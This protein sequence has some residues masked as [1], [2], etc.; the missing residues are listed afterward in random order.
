MVVT[1][2]DHLQSDKLFKGTALP[3]KITQ[4]DETRYLLAIERS[5]TPAFVS[6]LAN[7][8]V[9]Y[10]TEVVTGTIG[11]DLAVGTVPEINQDYAEAL[12]RLAGMAPYAAE[13][14][15]RSA[16]EAFARQVSGFEAMRAN[17]SNVVHLKTGKPYLRG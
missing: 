6:V 2:Y 15:V 3:V 1:V 13:D 12:W 14:E 16:F 8:G 4:S 11:G 5:G 17:Y 7:D 9:S 10:P